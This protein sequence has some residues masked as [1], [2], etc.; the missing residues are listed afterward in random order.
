[1]NTDSYNHTIWYRKL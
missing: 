1:L